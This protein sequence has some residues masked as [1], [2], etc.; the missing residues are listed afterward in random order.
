MKGDLDVKESSSP[1]TK[2]SKF[3]SCVGDYWDGLVTLAPKGKR[4]VELWYQVSVLLA[5]MAN[6]ILSRESP[7]ALKGP[8][9]E[10]DHVVSR[11]QRSAKR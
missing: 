7:A 4:R 3:M 5:T 10:P 9:A 2:R 1:G 11:A 6:H 8:C